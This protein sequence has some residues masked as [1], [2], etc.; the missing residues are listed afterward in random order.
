M[1][2]LVSLDIRAVA[3]CTLA[4]PFTARQH[5]ADSC[6]IIPA[7]LGCADAPPYGVHGSIHA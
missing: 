6:D 5:T 4:M 7:T 1:V 2:R 3:G